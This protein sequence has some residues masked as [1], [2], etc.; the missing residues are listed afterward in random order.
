VEAGSLSRFS[1]FADYL[2]DSLQFLSH[3]LVSCSDLV[4]RVRDLASQSY[5]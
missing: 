3:L 1:L 5:S 2:P 4:K